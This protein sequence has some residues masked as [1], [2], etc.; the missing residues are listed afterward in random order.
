MKKISVVVP[1]YNESGNVI[2]MSEKV[3]EI[4]SKELPDYDYELIFIDNYS[5]DNTRAEIAMACA[6][7]KKVKAIFNA[8]NFGWM[9]SPYYGITQSTGDCTVLMC[10]D[11]QEPPEMIPKFVKAWEEGYRI[12]VGIKTTSKESKFKYWIRSKYYKLMK[13]M[14]DVE[15]IEHYTGFGLYD[16]SFVDVMRKIK[17]PMPYIRGIVSELGFARKE[18]EYEQQQ[19]TH[20]KSK[21]NFFALYDTAMLGITS[22]TKN[23]LRIAT[24]AGLTLSAISLGIALVYL[25]LKLVFWDSFPMGMAPV[26]IGVFL[27]GAVQLFFIGLLGE[28]IMNI[29]TRVM[30]RPLVVEEGRLNFEDDSSDIKESEDNKK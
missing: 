4:F 27:M 10:A 8:K 11:F 6:K 7:N 19:R 1:T 13:K 14:S 21:G 17:D 24:F 28:Y 23:G 15:Q 22:Y 5:K 3:A 20:G 16:K 26:L 9:R 18:I 2:P 12:V 25:I 30:G 29:N